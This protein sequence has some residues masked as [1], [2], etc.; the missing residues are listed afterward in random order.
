MLSARLDDN[1][2]AAPVIDGDWVY[3]AGGARGLYRRKKDGSGNAQELDNNCRAA[4][5]IDG[6]WVYFAGGA[7]G[8]YRRKKDG[9]GNAQELDQWCG[10]SPVVSGNHVYYLGTSSKN[11]LYRKVKDGLGEAEPLDPNGDFRPWIDGQTIYWAGGPLRPLR[12]LY[13]GDLDLR[14]IHPNAFREWMGE[15]WSTIKDFPLWQVVLP[16]A[17]DAGCYGDR[18]FAGHVGVDVLRG[19]SMSVAQGSR[20]GDQLRYGIRYLD[21]RFTPSPALPP[22]Y[23]LR[24]YYIFHGPDV[25]DNTAQTILS[26]VKAFLDSTQDEI[27]LLDMRVDVGSTNPTTRMLAEEVSWFAQALI[28]ELDENRILRRS[29]VQSLGQKNPAACTPNQLKDKSARVIVLWDSQYAVTEDLQDYLW[30]STHAFQVS[31]DNN[32]PTAHNTTELKEGRNRDLQWWA[33]TCATTQTPEQT[34]WWRLGVHT[35]EFDLRAG[36]EESVPLVIRWLDDDSAWGRS[37]WNIVAADLFRE[38]QYLA[39]VR[40]VIARNGQHQYITGT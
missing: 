11:A 28:N 27:V 40:S 26:D 34:Y 2:R 31:K 20:V 9:S 16:G 38:E 5:V 15:R 8:L 19:S 37:P 23:D 33:H 21:L 17:H 36:A 30:D 13:K 12:S 39:L 3:F 32:Y 10:D 35:T 14:K 29:T 7:H 25:F 6:D 24:Q 4:P 18:V 1:C 22:R